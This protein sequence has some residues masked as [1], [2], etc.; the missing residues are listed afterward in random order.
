MAGT[1]D[2]FYSDAARG[3]DDFRFDHENDDP[4]E[5][6]PDYWDRVTARAGDGRGGRSG[7]ATTRGPAGRPA[8]ASAGRAVPAPARRAVPVSAGRASPVSAGRAGPAS[9]GR[10]GP[11]SGGRAG[12]VAGGRAAADSDVLLAIQVLRAMSPD[13]SARTLAKRLAQCGWPG[14]GGDTVRELLAG[15]PPRT[16]R[17][18]TAGNIALA[19]R[20]ALAAEP[21]MAAPATAKFLR[22]IGWP[23]LTA[24]HVDVTRGG[25]GRTTTTARRPDP[26]RQ[27]TRKAG[28][29]QTPHR[30]AERRPGPVGR[31]APADVD[32]LRDQELIAFHRGLE[33]GPRRPRVESCP[34]C[35][36]AIS[37]SGA[38]RCS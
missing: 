6:T 28:P 2:D 14:Y 18:P 11:A 36:V 38:C 30:R 3:R 7:A 5:L 34:S 26:P 22:R 16:R 37:P 25:R 4:A 19:V 21:K 29:E 9:A 33:S 20:V 24:D 12:P 35:E 10:A 1:I 27:A 32:R 23:A 31:S 15:L 13:V 8:P 17:A